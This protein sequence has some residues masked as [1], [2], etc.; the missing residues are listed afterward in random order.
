M[1]LSTMDFLSTN[2]S[3]KYKPLTHTLN[4]MHEQYRSWEYT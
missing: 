2:D 1:K 4:R 3:N